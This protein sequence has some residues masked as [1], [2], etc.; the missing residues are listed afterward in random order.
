M[1]STGAG[2]SDLARDRIYELLKA[3]ILSGQVAPGTALSE[4]VLARQHGVSRTPA[5]EAIHRL[6]LEGLVEAVPKRGTFVA[7]LPSPREVREL[8]ELR[9][10]I[11]GMAARLAA[12]RGT[13]DGI[14]DL[15]RIRDA[16]AEAVDL[17]TR[18]VLA[19]EWIVCIDRMSGNELLAVT[20][21]SL[22]DR[23]HRYRHAVMRADG[24]Y[25]HTA[26]GIRRRLADAIEARDGDMA[27]ELA[28]EIVRKVSHEV[29]RMLT[30][31]W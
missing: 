22:L 2:E 11:A 21:Q 1:R 20:N 27:E 10:A 16:M 28:R 26:L 19:D 15:H 3:E 8:Y 23:L 25:F 6:S 13:P 17:N 24:E 5:R 29:L 30:E 18:G 14:A 9:E 7:P 31:V 4:N 12:R